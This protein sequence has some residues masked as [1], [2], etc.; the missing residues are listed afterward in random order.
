MKVIWERNEEISG[1]SSWR[2]E[3]GD[4]LTFQIMQGKQFYPLHWV[5]GG[6]GGGRTRLLLSP[7]PSSQVHSNARGTQDLEPCLLS[8]IWRIG[9]MPVIAQT[10]LQLE[11]HFKPRGLLPYP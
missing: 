1:T 2:Q 4:A 3:R 10:F 6:F 9:W 5:F 11:L 7:C 8:F